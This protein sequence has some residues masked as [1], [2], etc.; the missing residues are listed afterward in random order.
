MGWGEGRARRTTWAWSVLGIPIHI[1]ASWFMILALMTWSLAR[2][3][4][5]ETY[6]G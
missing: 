5:P 1:D 6:S 2:G 3:Y 4:F